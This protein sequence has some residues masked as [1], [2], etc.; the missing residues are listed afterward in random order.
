MSRDETILTVLL[1]GPSTTQLLASACNM[2][3]RAVRHRIRRLIK[4]GYVFSPERG[5]YRLAASGVA[6]VPPPH[7]DEDPKRPGFFHTTVADV[8]EGRRPRP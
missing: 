4:D 5:V 7:S 2:G 8:L 1:D 3:E 6:V